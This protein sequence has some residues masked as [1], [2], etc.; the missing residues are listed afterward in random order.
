LEIHSSF[1]GK[2]VVI[3]IS[4]QVNHLTKTREFYY[5]VLEKIRGGNKFLA[6]DCASMDYAVSGFLSKVLLFSKLV[7][8]SEGELVLIPSEFMNSLLKTTG[9]AELIRSVPSADALL[10]DK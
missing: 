7:A 5:F 6:I 2:W 3:E 1:V 4:G 9:H 10:P 8:D